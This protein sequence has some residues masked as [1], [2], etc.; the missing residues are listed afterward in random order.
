MLLTLSEASKLAGVSKAGLYKAIRRGVVSAVRD[1]VSGAWRVDVSELGRVYALKSEVEQPVDTVQTDRTPAR[2]VRDDVSADRQH[3]EA[4]IAAL[5]SERDYLR[6]ALK[7]ES[8]ERRQLV[9]LLTG[10]RPDADLSTDSPRLPL[11]ILVTL[12]FALIVAGIVL[13]IRPLL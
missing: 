12:A 1:D 5:E 4:R 10:P 6:Q 3:Y 2:I 9:R 7:L 11:T 13:A 8:E